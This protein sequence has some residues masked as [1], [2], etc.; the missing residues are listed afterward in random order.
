MAVAVLKYI[1]EDEY[2]ALEEAAEE[3]HEYLSG[4]IFAMAGSSPEHALITSNAAI[5]IASLGRPHGCN[6]YSSD[7]RIRVEKTGLNTYPDVTLVCGKLIR[8]AQRPAGA[9]NPTLIVEVLSESTREYDRGEKWRHYQTLA[10]LTDYLLIW[11]DRPWVEHYVRMVDG[12]WMYRLIEGSESVV[13]I[14]S[15]EGELLLAEVYRGVE[16]PEPPVLR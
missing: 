14:E 1:S 9:T 4:Q 13:N 7:L 12:A 2:L 5:E 8:T 15:I 6:V 3:K 11:Q 10:S 16:F